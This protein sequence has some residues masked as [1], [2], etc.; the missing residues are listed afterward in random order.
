MLGLV[1]TLVVAGA[2][3]WVVDHLG[4]HMITYVPFFCIK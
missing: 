2:T 4:Y 1:I 3:V